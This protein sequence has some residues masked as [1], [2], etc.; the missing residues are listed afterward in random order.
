MFELQ[1]P[2]G[3]TA[4]TT[5]AA[6]AP[7]KTPLPVIIKAEAKPLPEL[8]EKALKITSTTSAAIEPKKE[9]DWGDD[10]SMSFDTVSKFMSEPTSTNDVKPISPPRASTSTIQFDTEELEFVTDE[11]LLKS[12]R[13]FNTSPKKETEEN[14][15]T[16]IDVKEEHLRIFWFDAYEDPVA[17]PGRRF[18]LFLLFDIEMQIT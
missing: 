3:K 17:Q 6:A 8:V 12:A 4:A 14:I 1:K 7:I 18:S 16:N 9:L 11:Q 15:T 2:K 13:A 10:D 5:T